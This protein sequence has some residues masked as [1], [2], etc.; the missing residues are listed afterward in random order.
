MAFN[1]N[2]RCINWLFL[3][4]RAGYYYEGSAWACKNTR[5]FRRCF[6]VNTSAWNNK[7]HR[8]NPFS[9]NSSRSPSCIDRSPTLCGCYWQRSSGQHP[10]DSRGWDVRTDTRGRYACTQ[11]CLQTGYEILSCNSAVMFPRG[12][13]CV[14]SGRKERKYFYTFI[15]IFVYFWNE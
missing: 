9:C 8:E 4:Q 10:T 13:P 2:R 11:Y 5:R 15:F 7:T 6:P 12:Q 14:Y 1:S 3:H